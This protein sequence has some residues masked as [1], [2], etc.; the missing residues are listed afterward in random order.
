MRME[1]L[2]DLDQPQEFTKIENQSSSFMHLF[3]H[4][5]KKNDQKSVEFI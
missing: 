3:G 4:S 1:A 5:P 2:I